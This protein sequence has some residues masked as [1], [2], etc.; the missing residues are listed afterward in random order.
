V[1]HAR[2]A[3]HHDIVSIAELAREAIDQL[4]ALRG[5]DLWRA[6]LARSEPIEDGLRATIDGTGR[7]V[8]GT[9]DDAVV[10]Y[11][12]I[13]FATLAD[14]RTLAMITD[15]YVTPSARG[16]GVGEAMMDL[17]ESCARQGGAV[18]LDSLALPGDRETKNFFESFGL[19]ARAILVHRS[20][21]DDGPE[22]SGDGHG[23]P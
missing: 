7:L 18:G 17:L 21:L 1:E 19:K 10:G 2:P 13:E 23:P 6:T 11:G 14:G 8:V 20:L 22:A 3:G 5:G 9:V 4:S 15:L 12:A 16:I